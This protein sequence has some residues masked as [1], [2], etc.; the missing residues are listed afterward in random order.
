MAK[1]EKEKRSSDKEEKQQGKGKNG[2]NRD[3]S[4]TEKQQ[5]TA[6]AAF[7]LLADEEAVNPVLSSLFAAKVNHLFDIQIERLRAHLHS[8]RHHQRQSRDLNMQP[9]GPT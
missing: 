5:K 6:S 9:M 3:K 8:S 1:H 4:K 7:S 2:K